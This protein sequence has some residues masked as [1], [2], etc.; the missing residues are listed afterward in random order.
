MRGRKGCS[1]ARGCSEKVDLVV[2]FF[3]KAK[4]RKTLFSSYNTEFVAFESSLSDL[5][6]HLLDYSAPSCVTPFPH[7]LCILLYTKR[8]CGKD[9]AQ[10]G[11][12]SLST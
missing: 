3:Y 1:Q 10:M 12:K 2:K 11:L 7:L 6:L 5:A 9:V 4:E 8:R